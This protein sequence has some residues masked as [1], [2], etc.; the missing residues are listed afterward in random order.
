VKQKILN[1][2]QALVELFEGD[3]AIYVLAVTGQKNYLQ[4][5]DKTTFDSLSETCGTFISNADLLNRNFETFKKL[6]FQLYQVVFRN[7]YL[8]AGRI[9]ISSGGKYF[10]F[11][12]L[13][14]N[15][16]PLTYF[17]EDHAVT[18][19]YSARYLLNDFSTQATFN[20]YTFLGIAPVEYGN[21]LAA[22][23]GS[24]ESI[25]RV[26]NYFSNATSLV[27]GS[28]SKNNFLKDYYK[29][30]II[31]LYTH[32]KGGYN[33]EPTIYF[34]DSALLLSDLFYESKPSTDLIVLS[35]CE[36]AEGKLYNG[37]GVFSFNREF[38]ALGIPSAISNLWKVDDRSSYEITELFYKYLVQGLPLDV[39]LQRAKKEFKSISSKEK[40]LPYY[41]AGSILVGQ[42]NPIH[43]QKTFPWRW[44]T[45]IAFALLLLG[46]GAMKVVRRKV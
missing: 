37:E 1:D 46:L 24:D 5:I 13:V 45:A 3:S 16:Q 4:K 23:Q 32:A 10:P 28:A 12:A 39:A 11:E 19:T 27:R 15:T 29:Y 21:G 18:Y 40:N 31:Q 30:K 26:Q 25:K 41:W 22:L 44:A 6:S 9:I 34:S 20:S 14:V 35:A 8:P 42:G 38:A 33:S 36:T 17:V 43:V 2:H 7:I